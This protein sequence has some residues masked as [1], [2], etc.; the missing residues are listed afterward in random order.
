MFRARIGVDQ[1][2]L[3]KSRDFQDTLIGGEA[4]GI[5]WRDGRKKYYTQVTRDPRSQGAIDLQGLFIGYKAYKIALDYYLIA[6]EPYNHSLQ[7]SHTLLTR[8]KTIGQVGCGRGYLQASIRWSQ[9]LEG[10]DIQ[11][12]LGCRGD[13]QGVPQGREPRESLKAYAQVYPRVREM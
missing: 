8:E 5:A 12:T 9:S 11:L 3:Y 6:C 4:W 10:A 7:R 1:C 13:L 2:I